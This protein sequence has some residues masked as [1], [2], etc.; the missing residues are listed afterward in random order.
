[1]ISKFLTSPLMSWDISNPVYSLIGNRSVDIQVLNRKS[2]LNDWQVDFAKELAIS[3]QTLV[4]TD[5]DQKIIWVNDGFQA[6][7]GY[8]PD[9]AIGKRPAFLQGPNTSNAV[10]SRIRKKLMIGGRISETITNYKK[11]GKAY[12]CLITIIPLVDSNQRI[13]HYLALEREAA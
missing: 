5:M 12:E 10:K 3:Y 2:I 9:F 4:L 13:T 7:T 8:T 1:M 11:N 6:M